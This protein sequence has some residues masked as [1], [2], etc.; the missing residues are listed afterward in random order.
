[1]SWTS[2]M[3]HQFILQKS[4]ILIRNKPFNQRYKIWMEHRL[5]MVIH[6]EKINQVNLSHLYLLFS[7]M[8]I[9]DFNCIPRDPFFKSGGTDPDVSRIKLVIKG[10]IIS[11]GIFN[12]VLTFLYFSHVWLLN[13]DVW[14]KKS[15]GTWYLL[16]QNTLGGIQHGPYYQILTNYP[17][18]QPKFLKVDQS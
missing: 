8:T 7:L 1:M 9:L 14:I 15:K 6:H 17:P 12:F 11:E 4:A 3:N 10:G 13:L 2:Y 16:V 18:Y 5:C